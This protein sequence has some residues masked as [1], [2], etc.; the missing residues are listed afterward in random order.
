MQH[1]IPTRTLIDTGVPASRDGDVEPMAGHGDTVSSAGHPVR[2]A[3]E[4]QTNLE[5]GQDDGKKSQEPHRSH[6]T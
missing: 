2:V 6:R 3:R 5:A 1:R 4:R